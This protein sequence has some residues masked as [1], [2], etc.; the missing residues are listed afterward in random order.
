MLFVCV[1]AQSFKTFSLGV[2]KVKVCE[3]KMKEAYFHAMK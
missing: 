2:F 1:C 3:S